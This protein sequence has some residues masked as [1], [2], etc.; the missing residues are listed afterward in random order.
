[1]HNYFQFLQIRED[2]LF[3]LEPMSFNMYTWQN[4]AGCFTGDSF[5]TTITTNEQLLQRARNDIT[6]IY[7]VDPIEVTPE[8][9]LI[10]QFNDARVYAAE[11]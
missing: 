3:Y 1:M 11:V 5:D 4:N 6:S 9:L 10:S 7:N 2:G 8:Y